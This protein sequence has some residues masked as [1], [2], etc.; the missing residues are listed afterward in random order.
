MNIFSLKRKYKV[1]RTYDEGIC[2]TELEDA[3]KDGYEFVRASEFVPP[4]TRDGVRRFG[5]IEYILVKEV[6]DE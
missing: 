3:F 2:T 4:A 5:Y 6:G 1:V